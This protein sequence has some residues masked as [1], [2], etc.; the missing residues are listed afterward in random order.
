MNKKV[1]FMAVLMTATM[2]A[3]AAN[4][5]TKV[6]TTPTDWTGTYLIVC[7]SQS[8]V[9][10]GGAD[11]TKIDTKG[12]DA[13][14][15]TGFSISNDTLTGSLTVDTATFTIGAT[16]NETWPW[17]IKSAS[18]LYLGHKDTAD[19]GLSTELA[20]EE[21]CKQSLSID[22]DGNFVAIPQYVKNEYALR[23]N[24]DADQ[25]RFRYFEPT[26]KKAVQLYKLV[27]TPSGLIQTESSKSQVSKMIRN[28]QMVII[29]DGKEYSVLGH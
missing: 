19:N 5:Y 27:T 28:G 1:F 8:V 2:A 10:N 18:G 3:S 4:V 26:K 15:T 23:Y 22:A 16:D 21:K 17:Y 25:L 29:K 14:L 9:F 20:L 12:G 13:I 7:E 6:T 24:K 11:T